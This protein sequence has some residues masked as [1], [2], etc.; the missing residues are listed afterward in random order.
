MSSPLPTHIDPWKFAT[1]GKR[2]QGE[3]AFER[4]PRLGS[5]LSA[6]QGQVAVT[7][8]GSGNHDLY[9]IAGRLRA[10]VELICQRCLAPLLLPL[11]VDLRL[12][13]VHSEA[14]AAELA[15]GFEPLL[16]PETQVVVAEMVE[17]ELI[18]ALPLVP[19]HA[20][21]RQCEMNGFTAPQAEPPP[22]PFAVLSTLLQDPELKE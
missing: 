2:L 7:L 21:L 6:S 9:F 8:E 18:L 14:Q 13:P 17:D 3:I 10:T 1:A 11:A 20:D 19:L 16:A 5:L 4:M 12:V 15:E 22:N